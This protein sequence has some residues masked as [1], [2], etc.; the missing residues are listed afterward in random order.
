MRTRIFNKMMATEVED[1]LTRGGNTIFVAVGVTEVHGALPV[2]CEA[3]LPEAFALEMAEQSDGLAL[4]N[5][6]YFFPGGTIISNATIQV[7]VR[8]GIDYLMMLSRSLLSQGFK[9]IIF[10]S[11]H[12]PASLYVDAMCRDFFQETKIHICHVVLAAAFQNFGPKENNPMILFDK[13]VY[14]AYKKMKQ[15]EFLPVDPDAKEIPQPPSEQNSPL[16]KLQ[17]A[18]RPFGSRA[19]VYYSSPEQHCG[20]KLFANETERLAACE[21]GEKMICDTVKHMDLEGLKDAIDGYHGF[22]QGIV[23]KFP[24]IK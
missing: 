22:V 20:G 10:V 1:Y 21:A 4:I 7:T 15:M 13:M 8:D 6:P 24:R 12:F 11:V 16:L 14:G 18:L 19:S 9:K 5:L 3:I 2:D 17:T 23:E